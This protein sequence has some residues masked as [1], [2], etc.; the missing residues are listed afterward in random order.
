MGI[1]DLR[2]GNFI[3]INDKFI[4]INE[5]IFLQ[6]LENKLDYE[7]VDL[8]DSWLI[9]FGYRYSIEKHF[10]TGRNK[11][12]NIYKNNNLFYLTDGVGIISEEIKTVSQL[13]NLYYFL[14]NK[15]INEK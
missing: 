13:Q 12:A 8:T 7:L 9:K 10:Y 14:I 6:I 3:K 2:I 15:E 11:N 4:Q 5:E 1:C